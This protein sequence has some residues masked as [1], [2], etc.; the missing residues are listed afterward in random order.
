MRLKLSLPTPIP[1]VET[2]KVFDR[3]GGMIGRESGCDWVLPDPDKVISRHH[4]EVTYEDGCYWF[5]DVSA[6]GTFINDSDKA[7][8][9]P[10]EAIGG[11]VRIDARD[12]TS[13]TIGRYRIDVALVEP[14]SVELP[15]EV[16]PGKTP[17]I[18]SDWDRLGSGDGGDMEDW[19]ASPPPPPS[20]PLSPVGSSPEPDL[21]DGPGFAAFLEGAG[22]SRRDLANADPVEVMRQAGVAF[23]LMVAGLHGLLAA[24]AALKHEMHIDRTTLSHNP[25]KTAPDPS[26]A[27]WSLLQPPSLNGMRAD[28]A[29]R[30]AVDDIESHEMA[31][32]AGMNAALGALLDRFAPERLA[33]GLNRNSLLDNLLPAA[34]KAKYWQA[35]EEQYREIID[36]A[37]CNFHQLFGEEFAKAYYDT[38]WQDSS[39]P[40]RR[41]S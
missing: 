39:D 25:L 4:C 31:M 24:R 5:R 21:G 30:E 16:W 37:E 33:Q 26:M 14:E 38:A 29:V 22:V 23:R 15:R 1:N 20:D 11:A 41:R 36:E 8:G 18:P 13:L 6:N 17:A 32:A 10:D 2:I 35:Y 27:V 9:A 34:R 7:I 19:P 12:V 28:H 40:R 3:G